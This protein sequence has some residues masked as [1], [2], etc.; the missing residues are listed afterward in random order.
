MA[1]DTP[2]I[3]PVMR[4]LSQYISNALAQDLPDAVAEKAKHHLLDTLA[5]MVSGAHMVP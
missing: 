5:S 3:S 4:G 1:D 2:E